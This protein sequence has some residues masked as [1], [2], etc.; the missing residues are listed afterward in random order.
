[1]MLVTSMFLILCHQV[2]SA[3]YLYPE[4]EYLGGSCYP[5]DSCEPTRNES[6]DHLWN[7]YSCECGEHC[8]RYA[9]CCSNSPHLGKTLYVHYRGETCKKLISVSDPVVMVTRCSERWRNG[10]EVL[11]K[12]EK[13]EDDAEDPVG[14]IPVTSLETNVTYK[15]FFC[16]VCNHDDRNTYLWNIS[17]YL[18]A[19]RTIPM[20]Q[21]MTQ[22]EKERYLLNNMIYSEEKKSWGLVM[23]DDFHK[24]NLQFLVPPNLQ[25][26]VKKC[27]RNMVRTCDPSYANNSS[28]QY[29]CWSYY[30]PIQIKE[31]GKYVKK[32]R[33]I[34]CAMCNNVNMT[35]VKDRK[36]CKFDVRRKTTRPK[37]SFSFALLLDINKDDG[38]YVGLKKLCEN[39]QKWDPFFKKCRSLVCAVPNYIVKNGRCV[40]DGAIETKY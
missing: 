27:Y 39:D 23:N 2:S 22:S 9:T 24:L 36:M 13:P 4:M 35:N 20:L 6:D 15:N 33:N 14:M 21:N 7:S 25:K 5:R 38:N 8:I 28:L 31:E 1:M 40:P 17:L 10:F 19:K 29:K 12:C 26:F 18:S 16:A 34:H 32:Y 30:S 37:P 11:T 3:E